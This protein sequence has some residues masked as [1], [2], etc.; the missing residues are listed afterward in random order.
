MA[1]MNLFVAV[2]CPSKWN[3]NLCKK[4]SKRVQKTKAGKK[5]TSASCQGVA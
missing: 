3:R 4:Y 1:Y 5:M 2:E